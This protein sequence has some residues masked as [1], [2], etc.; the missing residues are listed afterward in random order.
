ML[1]V[2]QGFSGLLGVKASRF[3]APGLSVP[4]LPG[5]NLIEGC[6]GFWV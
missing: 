3:E 2:R 1:E 4:G 5:L 6:A